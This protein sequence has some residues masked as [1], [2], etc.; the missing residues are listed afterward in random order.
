M[1]CA[2]AVTG[3]V[4]DICD[5]EIAGV[6]DKGEGRGGGRIGGAEA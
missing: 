2:G 5:L 3:L 4:V 6:A 1:D